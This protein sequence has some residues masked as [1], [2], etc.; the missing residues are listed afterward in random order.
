MKI[1]KYTTVKDQTTGSKIRT[2][3]K[4]KRSSLRDQNDKKRTQFLE[5][6]DDMPNITEDEIKHFFKSKILSFDIEEAKES[7]ENLQSDCRSARQL[8]EDIMKRCQAAKS[9]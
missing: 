9:K 1:E 3:P 6:I 2:I 7:N 4:R 8:L 5:G